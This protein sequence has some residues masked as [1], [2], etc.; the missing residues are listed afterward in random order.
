MFAI[1]DI[2]TTGLN[3]RGDRIT[4]IAILL[5]D[6][7]KITDQ[8]NTL[9]NPERRIPHFITG[10]TGIDNKMVEKA[11][12]FCEVAKEIVEITE[13]RIIVAHNAAF[14]YNFIKNEFKWLS[15]E[16]KRKTLCTVKLSRK[17]IPDLPSYSLEN[18]CKKL[19]IENHSKHRAMGDAMATNQLFSYLLNIEKDLANISLVDLN[20]N[21]DKEKIDALP[22]KAGVYYFYDSQNKI[23]YIGKSTNIHSRVLS[24]LSC[25]TTKK[26]VEMRNNIADIDYEITGSELVALLLESDEI[27]KHMPLYNKAQR[28]TAHTHGLF[29]YEDENNYKRLKLDKVT[30]ENTPLTAFK[31]FR[32]AK[33]SLYAIVENFNLCQKLCGLYKT[34]GACFHLQIKQCNGACLQEESAEDYNKRVIDAI[35]SYTYKYD[36][37]IIIDEGRTFDERAVVKVVNGKYIGFGFVNTDYL[38]GNIDILNDCIKEYE[39]NKDVRNIVFSYLKRNNVEKVI[40]L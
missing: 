20:S 22:E 15:Y 19:N 7:E 39:N 14:D 1:I 6:G 32:S 30:K 4:E 40:K 34:D 3:S 5:H 25:N 27:K 37:F 13:N 35:S 12:R 36:S 9:I 18:L 24:H 28:R 8:F 29:I 23:I 11:P 2:E 16:Y 38:N 17:L 21:L 26:A 31:S 10:L 33:E